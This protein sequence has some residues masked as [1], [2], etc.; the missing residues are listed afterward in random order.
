MDDNMVII[1]VFVLIMAVVAA[2]IAFVVVPTFTEPR[3]EGSD[4]SDL[5]LLVHDINDVNKSGYEHDMVQDGRLDALEDTSVTDPAFIDDDSLVGSILDQLD[6]SFSLSTPSEN[7]G[8]PEDEMASADTDDVA[9]DTTETTDD[10]ADDTTDETTDDAADDT[11]DETTDD[12]TDAADDAADN[13]GEVD[14]EEAGD[15]TETFSAYVAKIK[16]GH[17]VMGWPTGSMWK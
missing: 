4:L 17:G 14:G 9:D 16:P 5:S 3:E 12:T 11:T 1:L 6:F 8:V 13:S 2:L 10:A 15:Q 7:E